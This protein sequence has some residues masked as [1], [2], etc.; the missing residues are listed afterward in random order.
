MRR[1]Q[2]LPC[3]NQRVAAARTNFLCHTMP[4]TLGIQHT[5][6]GYNERAS[7]QQEEDCQHPAGLRSYSSNA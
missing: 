7:K 4:E 2:A 6:L 5:Y 1:W 3:D